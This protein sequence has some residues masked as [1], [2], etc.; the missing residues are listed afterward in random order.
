MRLRKGAILQ[1]LAQV[2]RLLP[3]DEADY[4]R[5][6][7]KVWP[8]VLQT[9]ADCNI[10]NYSIFLRNGLLFAYFEYHGEDYASDLRKMAA[11]PHT[12]RWWKITDAMQVPLADAEPGERWSPLHE[13]F[14]FDPASHPALQLEQA[15]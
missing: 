1:R 12:Q 11:C 2:I 15:D 13:V 4:I 9:I 3:Q 5:Y 14:Y 8:E 10:A 6:H 7:E